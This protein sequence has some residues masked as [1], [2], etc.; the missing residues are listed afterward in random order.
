MTRV[1]SQEGKKRLEELQELIYAEH[2]HLEGLYMR[3]PELEFDPA[4]M[5][6]AR[7]LGKA[8]HKVVS[9]RRQ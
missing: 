1:L 7:S 3:Y 6:I 5:R 2:K 8:V 9:S 4:D